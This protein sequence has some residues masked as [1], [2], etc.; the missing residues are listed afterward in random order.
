MRGSTSQVDVNEFKYNVNKGYP[1]QSL[2]DVIRDIT[3][4][5]L[6]QTYIH[7]LHRRMIIKA[8]LNKSLVELEYS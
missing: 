6:I 4:T 3:W 5:Y 8:I 2:G 7:V 1:Y